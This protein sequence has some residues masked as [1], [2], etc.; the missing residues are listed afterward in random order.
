MS[1][2]SEASL[3]RQTVAGVCWVCLA[4]WCIHL[5]AAGL[6]FPFGAEGL[7]Y[8]DALQRILGLDAGAVSR[9]AVWQPLTYAFL[10]GSGFH[11]LANLFGLW[12]T[13]GTLV[14][15]LGT[16]RFL[17]LFT[18]GA[19]AGAVGFLISAAVD[20]RLSAGVLCIGASAAVTAFIGAVTTLVPTQRVTLWVAVLPIPLR[21]LWLLP[22]MLLFLLGEAWLL[23]ATT[24]YGAHVGGWL[25]GLFAGACFRKAMK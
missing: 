13:G 17:W 3:G 12:L 11:L 2:H 4:L 7:S 19:S 22:M 21:A 24:A 15:L 25:A 5:L 10:H 18:L 16:R 14:E 9:G 8:T 1:A 20:P 6:S 23:P